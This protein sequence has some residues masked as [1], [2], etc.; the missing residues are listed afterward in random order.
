[1]QIIVPFFTEEFLNIVVKIKIVGIS[2]FYIF[3][4][5]WTSCTVSITWRRWRQFC[6]LTP[7]QKFEKSQKIKV[8]PKRA[9]IFWIL[10]RC[11]STR[12]IHW[13]TYQGYFRPIINIRT[14]QNWSILN[15]S[16]LERLNQQGLVRSS[17][18]RWGY[19]GSS[20]VTWCLVIL[21]NVWYSQMM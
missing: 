16:N 20:K 9:P 12:P 7:S 2:F 21:K 3:L 8:M 19:T 18:F 10:R 11:L 15:R 14:F 17:L 4:F 6:P 5:W 13:K 1:M